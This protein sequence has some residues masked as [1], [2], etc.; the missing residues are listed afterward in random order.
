M[1]KSSFPHHSG[2]VV[3][4]HYTTRYGAVPEALLE[5]VRLSLDSRAVAAWLAIKPTGWQISVTNLRLRLA[6][7]GKNM[8]GKDLWQRIALELQAAGYLERRKVNGQGGQWGWHI[9]FNP[10][11]PI[12]TVAGLAGYG[13]ASA[14]STGAG[15]D[16]HKEI[17]SLETPIEKSTTTTTTTTTTAAVIRKRRRTASSTE[18]PGK[19]KATDQ[20]GIHTLHFPK[21]NEKERA[22][23][24]KLIAICAIDSRQDVLDEVEGLPQDG[25]IKHGVIALT[26][27]LVQ[28]VAAG[29]FMLSAGHKVQIQREVRNGHALALSSTA[30]PVQALLPMSEDVL[31]ML[32]PNLR[33]NAREAMAREQSSAPRHSSKL[34]DDS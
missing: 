5:D 23:L 1:G 8:L 20:P 14:G 10:V 32:P 22:G 9:T 11:P 19:G 29:G 25:R 3:Q 18:Q 12:L 28:T 31:A 7:H 27:K 2:G 15:E 16:G 13:L 33:K 21:V 30:M 34:M 6:P 4:V 17:P 26:S 24:E